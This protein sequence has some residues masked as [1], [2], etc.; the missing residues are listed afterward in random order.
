MMPVQIKQKIITPLLASLLL[1]LSGCDQAS[2]I[3]QQAASSAAGMVSAEIKKQSDGAIEQIAGQANDVLQPLGIDAN[4][5]A[6]SVKAKGVLLA[7]KALNSDSSWQQLEQYQGQLPQ[8]IGLFTAVSPISAELKNILNSEHPV[9]LSLM[10][11]ASVLQSDGVLYV[12]G[13]APADTK[14]GTAWLMIDSKN[15]TLEAGLIRNKV[16]QIFSSKGDAL[17]RPAPVQ[18]FIQQYTAG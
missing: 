6:S 15:R 5:I 12:L 1:A 7:Q 16:A 18:K 2:Q 8:D 3:A 4:Q 13:K 9:F 17:L 14:S 10:S 11:S